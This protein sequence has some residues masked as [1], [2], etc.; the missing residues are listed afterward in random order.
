[1]FFS[2]HSKT[3][4]YE[5]YMEQIEADR[6]LGVIGLNKYPKGTGFTALQLD[7][8]NNIVKVFNVSNRSGKKYFVGENITDL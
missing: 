3:F 6:Y 4:K 5:R 2:K 1:M 7:K 8:H